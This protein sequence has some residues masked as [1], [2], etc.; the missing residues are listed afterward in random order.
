MKMG[1]RWLVLAC[2]LLLGTGALAEGGV[3][4]ARDTVV[5]GDRLSFR[6]INP[7][8]VFAM[9]ITV[10]TPSKESKDGQ[11]R[12]RKNGEGVYTLPD[13]FEGPNGEGIEIAENTR[14]VLTVY[15]RTNAGAKYTV[16]FR[17]KQPLEAV[18][19]AIPRSE[20]RM[21]EKSQRLDEMRAGEIMTVEVSLEDV[22]FV[23]LEEGEENRVIVSSGVA[24]FL[25]GERLERTDEPFA[26]AYSVPR[27]LQT[28]GF[29]RFEFENV[30]EDLATDAVAVASS[31]TEVP[32]S[33]PTEAPTSAPTEA[34]PVT[35]PAAQ[36]PSSPP[37]A[38]AA[39][40]SAENPRTGEPAAPSVAPGDE[41]G[42]ETLYLAAA[43]LALLAATAACALRLRSVTRQ[44]KSQQA[45]DR[46]ARRAED[47]KTVRTRAG[48]RNDG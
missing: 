3:T 24:L 6:C 23:F 15:G 21:F 26:G 9:G 12:W 36:S 45:G 18:R 37:T 35:P 31:P 48:K 10:G 39:E 28:E 38:K 34:P 11:Y 5:Y 2:A 41:D 32:T 19:G 16:E 1:F 43:T 42:R 13:S 20:K 40:P 46:R 27:D 4:L 47:E 8:D 33:L 7:E 17:G 25:D 30:S 14:Y 29:H 44:I 22:A